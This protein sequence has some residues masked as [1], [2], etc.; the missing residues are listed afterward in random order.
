MQKDVVALILG[1][2]TGTRLYPLT[3]LRAKPAVPIAGH[4]RLVDVPISNCINSGLD[5]IFVLTQF[6]SVSLHR[7]INQTY[8]FDLFSQGWVQILAAEQTLNNKDWYQGTADAV[9]KQISELKA[10]H[11]RDFVILSGDH[12]YRMDYAAFLHAHRIS[13]ADVTLAVLPVTAS[14]A[15]R[16]G[17]VQTNPDNAIRC[18]HEKPSDPALLASLATYPDPERPYLGSM[19]VYIF[20]AEVLY[21]LLAEES[22]SDFGKHILPASLKTCQ[23][24][25]WPFAGYWED[26][27]TIQA[28]YRANLALV[29]PNAPFS[30][31]DSERP[32]YTHPRFLPPSSVEDDCMLDRVLLAD[33]SKIV[34]SHITQSVIGVRSRIGPNARLTRTVMLGADYAES[35][36][37]RVANAAQGLPNIGIG[38]GCVIE[39]AIIDKN[40]RIG[41]GVI[42][43]YLPERA[44]FETAD[45]AVRDG[46]VIVLK[47]GV[48]PAGTVI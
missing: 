27:G 8:R 28:F 29:E 18:F 9:R 14:D 16:F 24:F 17:I 5:Q 19:G 20:R 15:S 32:I 3:K 44:D 46:L 30:F 36:T 35:E 41:D 26:I 23:V 6:N 21:R 11:A 12:L 40:A 39:S 2:G 43:R 33:G 13:Q 45:Y 47:N 34:R 4:Y 1:G 7:H 25:A 10:T 42:I 22:G 48:I 31:Y 38:A 37:T